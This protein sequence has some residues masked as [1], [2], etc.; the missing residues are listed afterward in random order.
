M[1]CNRF[2]A[3]HLALFL[4]F[5]PL[6]STAS[7]S[8]PK[9]GEIDSLNQMLSSEI[10]DTARIQVFVELTEVFYG[11]NKD[12]TELL[13]I[14]AIL[15]AELGLDDTDDPTERRS[16]QRS[17]CTLYETLGDVY[18]RTGAYLKSERS[19][20]K[21]LAIMEANGFDGRPFI[22]NQIAIVNLS[23]FDYAKSLESSRKSHELSQQI[24]NPTR[25]DIAVIA[26]ALH[27]IAIT[28]HQLGDWDEC[29]NYLLKSLAVAE[30]INHNRLA[31]QILGEIGSYYLQHQEDT[32][33]AIVYYERALTL[34]KN[35]K[36]SRGIALQ[37]YRLAA[38][39][40]FSDKQKA[41]ACIEE[42]L[43]YSLHQNPTSELVDLLHLKAKMKL[44]EGEL[45]EAEKFALEAF[46]HCEN[47]FDR[48][49]GKV[50]DVLASVY[51]LQQ[52]YE[53]AMY[54][55]EIKLAA[56]KK[57]N[58]LENQREGL[59][60]AKK[61]E[62][63]TIRAEETFQRELAEKNANLK[64]QKIGQLHSEKSARDL[65]IYGVTIISLLVFYLLFL[66]F[67][68]Y[69]RKMVARDLQ[70]EKEVKLLLQRVNML[71]GSLNTRLVEDTALDAEK[72][73]SN[74]SALMQT[75]L[76]KREIDVL[77]ELS[78]GKENKEIAS[79]LFLSVNTVRSHLLKIY[80]KLD[81]KNR[82]QAIK[83]A[84]NINRLEVRS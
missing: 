77:F 49:K 29:N 10:D 21:V 50:A 80:D 20:E 39:Y 53:Q 42:G 48:E 62:I 46:E 32:A 65:I 52:D 69:R 16:Y 26:F 79:D 59:N 55:H 54:Y 72:L 17:I 68:S 56:N 41:Y 58:N 81:V 4:F 12:T 31:A 43:S 76:T 30:K 14:Q 34:Q 67:R 27:S 83:K 36:R 23:L 47:K 18:F 84:E 7:L 74:L 6:C 57:V 40:E 9:Q 15:Q 37:L 2:F 51:K 25:E 78:K 5:I 63:K 44:K 22:L 73:N 24:P 70:A 75:P 1:R 61:L 45:S 19:Y 71:Q 82:T 38:A 11:F 60:A 28:Y 35:V 13:A 3:Q 8:N 33:Q 66:W 64:D